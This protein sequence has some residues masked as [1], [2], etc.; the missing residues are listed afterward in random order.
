MHVKCRK[1][2]SNMRDYSPKEERS[3]SLDYDY[4]RSNPPSPSPIHPRLSIEPS[5][6]MQAG[7]LSMICAQIWVNQ[8]IDQCFRIITRNNACLCHENTSLT[9]FCFTPFLWRIYYILVT[10]S[11]RKSVN[12]ARKPPEKLPISYPN[13]SRALFPE[14]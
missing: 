4:F 8:S 11:L 1:L 13:N 5:I 10:T 3:C 12:I 2:S 7:P 6:I 9:F 14:F